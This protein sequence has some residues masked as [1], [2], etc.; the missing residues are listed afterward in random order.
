MKKKDGAAGTP[1]TRPTSTGGLSLLPPP[2]GAK[3]A[4]LAP[5]SGEHLSVGGSVVQPAVSPSSGQCARV[6]APQLGLLF[7]LA[8][9]PAAFPP[10][11]TLV[12]LSARCEE[13]EGGCHKAGPAHTG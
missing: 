1:R 3:T 4:A 7:P 5:L 2:P 9:G 13:L 10:S 8:A 6:M 12:T 11:P